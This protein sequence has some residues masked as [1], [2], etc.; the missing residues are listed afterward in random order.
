M[1]KATRKEF[2]A[3]V[4]AGINAGTIKWGDEMPGNPAAH[5]TAHSVQGWEPTDFPDSYRQRIGGYV[6]DFLRRVERWHNNPTVGDSSAALNI[7]VEINGIIRSLEDAT[8]DTR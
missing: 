5:M 8:G 7:L 3:N 6:E 1:S 2:I 4:N